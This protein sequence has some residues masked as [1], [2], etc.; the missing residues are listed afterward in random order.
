MLFTRLLVPVDFSE[1]ST[2]ALKLAV[3]IAMRVGAR[4]TLLHIDGDTLPG[5]PEGAMG[6][7]HRLSAREVP[8]TVVV[9]MITDQGSPAERIN[10]HAIFP[11]TSLIESSLPSHLAE[12]KDPLFIEQTLKRHKNITGIIKYISTI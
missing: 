3:T 9:E 1:P 6:A 8:S 7:L 2:E 5:D 10:H 4:L 12:A 11:I